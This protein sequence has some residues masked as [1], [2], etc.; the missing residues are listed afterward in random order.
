MNA[1]PEEERRPFQWVSATII[2]VCIVMYALREYTWARWPPKTEADRVT[3][4]LHLGALSKTAIRN[5][6]WWRAITYAFAHAGR[7]HLIANMVGV[8]AVGVPLERKVG[9]VRFAQLALVTCLGSAAAV[10]LF[11]PPAML[12][13]GASGMVFGF[14]GALLLL[15][16]R[17]QARQLI[18]LLVLNLFISLIPG[19]SWQAHLGGFVFGLICGLQFRRDPERFSTRA[20]VLVAFATSLALFAAYRG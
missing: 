9:G 10:M 8:L 5:H 6:E 1:S 20:P 11:T 7:L 16:S 15:T 12:T 13:V 14:A 18:Q 2:A 4:S 19:V 17:E 3:L